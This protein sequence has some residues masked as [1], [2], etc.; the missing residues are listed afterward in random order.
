M[1][2]MDT[3]DASLEWTQERVEVTNF[4]GQFTVNSTTMAA[5]KVAGGGN[6]TTDAPL[7]ALNYSLA[8]APL[9]G[10]CLGGWRFEVVEPREL[11]SVE[12]AEP[13]NEARMGKFLLGFNKRAFNT[14]LLVFF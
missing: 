9:N 7:L 2:D 8:M 1:R 12:R 10:D 13:R 14:F 4:P 5:A 3:N 6:G 11:W